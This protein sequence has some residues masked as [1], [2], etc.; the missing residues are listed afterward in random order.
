MNVALWTNPLALQQSWAYI[1]RHLTINVRQVHHSY[2]VPE[3][4]RANHA[5]DQSCKGG[6]RNKQ[7]EQPETNHT[8]K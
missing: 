8:Q 5:S 2:C 6:N 3:S 4:R 1:K 7:K